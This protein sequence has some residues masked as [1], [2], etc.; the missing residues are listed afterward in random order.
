MKKKSSCLTQ[1]DVLTAK[2]TT[3]CRLNRASVEKQKTKK[4]RK[5]QKKIVACATM[6]CKID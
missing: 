3:H 6:E 1:C 2:Y 4:K 5:K